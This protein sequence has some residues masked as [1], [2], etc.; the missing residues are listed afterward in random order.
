MIASG[1]YA[2]ASFDEQ[3]AAQILPYTA[4]RFF[5]RADALRRSQREDACTAKYFLLETWRKTLSSMCAALPESEKPDAQKLFAPEYALAE[6]LLQG[7]EAPRVPEDA[8]LQRVP[9]RLFRA[10]LAMRA[11]E[12]GLSDTLREELS[13]IR[14]TF[15]ESMGLTNRIVY[16]ADGEHS[17][18]WIA[19]AVE[20]E[21]GCACEH[22]CETWLDFLAK[23]GLI[24]F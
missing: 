4:R 24:Q 13:R 23:A 21:T 11:F 8:S 9:K 20:A 12:A 3:T 16:A 10:P 22:F 6:Q 18:S 19:S 17:I 2:A 1:A 7:A 14:K 15:P 5:A